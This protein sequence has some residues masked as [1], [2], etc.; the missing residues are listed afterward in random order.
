[1][2][3]TPHTMKIMFNQS[4]PSIIKMV[5]CFNCSDQGFVPDNEALFVT[6]QGFVPGN[7]A[8]VTKEPRPRSLEKSLFLRGSHLVTV[9]TKII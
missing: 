6:Y 9:D 7:D 1:M 8:L 2:E 5:G 3:N 4:V